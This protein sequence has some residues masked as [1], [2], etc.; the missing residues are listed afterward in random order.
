MDGKKPDP[1]DLYKNYN[2]FF[3]FFFT[4]LLYGIIV[5]LGFILL[6]VPG[7]YLAV[8]YQFTPYIVVDKKIA[9]LAAMKEAAKLTSGRWMSIFLFDL[10]LIGLNILGALALGIGLLITIPTSVLAS[11]YLYR[12]LS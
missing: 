4:S 1:A 2:L 11:S 12:K 10:T 8:K 7:I 5:I 9:Y 6:I 3:R